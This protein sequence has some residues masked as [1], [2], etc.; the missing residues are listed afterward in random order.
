MLLHSFLQ[1]GEKNHFL[2]VGLCLQTVLASSGLV[3]MGRIQPPV[4]YFSIL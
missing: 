1:D 3:V 4:A 2:V